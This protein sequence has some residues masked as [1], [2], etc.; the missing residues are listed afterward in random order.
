MTLQSKLRSFFI[1]DDPVGVPPGPTSKASPAPV[2]SNTLSTPPS[3]SAAETAELDQKLQGVLMHAID[4]A[5]ITAY[6]ALDD[7]LESLADVVP[8]ENTRYRKALEILSKQGYTLPLILQ[9]IDKAIGALEESSRDFE[10]GQKAQFQSSVG[11]LHRSVED[12]T[13]RIAAKQA[14]VARLN[15]EIVEMTKKR[16]LDASSISTAQAEIDR[17]GGRY[18]VVYEIFMREI[19]GQRTRVDQRL[20]AVTP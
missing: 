5:G 14:E 19:Q 18:K 4:N 13:A 6:K 17:V 15:A 12:L 16:D 1:E 20:K 9:D 8:D 3:P 11:T 10:A 2:I 7:M